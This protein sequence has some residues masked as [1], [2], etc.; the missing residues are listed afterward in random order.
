MVTECVNV[1]VVEAS[2]SPSCK[3]NVCF[4]TPCGP[5]HVDSC[6]YCVLEC[7]IIAFNRSPCVGTKTALSA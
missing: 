4:V 1:R 2:S 3:C 7:E 6:V 5:L